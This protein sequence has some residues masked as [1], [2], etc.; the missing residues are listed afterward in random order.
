MTHLLRRSPETINAGSMADIAFLL[1][2]FYFMVTTVEDNK[3]LPLLLPP[4]QASP[5]T[6]PVASR[7]LFT[8]QLNSQ[9]E[10]LIEG[11]R[12]TS[13]E[14]VRDEI[15]TFVLNPQHL[16]HLSESPVKAV[17]SIKTDRGTSYKAYVQALDEVQAAYY[18]IYAERV[19]LTPHQLRALDE[20]DRSDKALYEKARKGI[21]MNISIAE[22]TKAQ[23]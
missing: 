15:K 19:G 2:T 21:P 12:R 11:E 18:E 5:I 7:N 17:V 20:S 22:P 9:N 16:A 14:G 10:V 1:L 4:W 23:D 6:A 8:V 3:G 13:W